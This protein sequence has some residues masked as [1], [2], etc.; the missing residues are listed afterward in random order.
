MSNSKL[1]DYWSKYYERLW[2]QKYS[3]KPTRKITI[4]LIKTYNKESLDILDIGCGTGQLISDIRQNF[5]NK[6]LNL[7]G[8]DYSKGMIEKAR[9]NIDYADFILK[10]ISDI[11]SLDNKFDIITCTHSLPYY[12]NQQKAISDMSNLLKKDGILII[13]CGSSNTV[14]DKFAFSLVKL[15]TGFAKYPSIKNLKYMTKDNL[16]LLKIV[17]IKEKFFMPTI[18]V[19]LF[20]KNGDVL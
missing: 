4:D 8:L 17:K 2:V 10:D 19:S 7:K 14:Y 20:K 9:K 12:A 11:N 15:T 16:E 5:K 18:I 1:W 6:S 13:A 3:L